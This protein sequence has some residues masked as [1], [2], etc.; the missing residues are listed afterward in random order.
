[1]A[2]DRPGVGVERVEGDHHSRNDHDERCSDEEVQDLAPYTHGWVPSKAWLFRAEDALCE[3]QVKDVD[4]ENSRVHKDLC[5][6]REAYVMQ[7]S[8][9]C[10]AKDESDGSCHTECE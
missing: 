7:S 5:R 6:D 10:D 9:P 8:C 3:D 4:D 1:M 2:A